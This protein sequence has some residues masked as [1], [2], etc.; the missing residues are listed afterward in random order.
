MSLPSSTGVAN[1]SAPPGSPHGAAI[2]I[3]GLYIAFGL[4]W[5][6]LSDWVILALGFTDDHAFLAAAI[7]G[8]A[9][10]GLTAMLLYTLVQRE[11]SRAWRS[12]NLLRAVVQETTD[13]VFVKDRKGRYLLANEAAARFIGRSVN[14]ILGRDDRELLDPAGAERIISNDQAIMAGGSVQT[15]EESITFTPSG[16]KHTFLATKAPYRDATG[17]VI[18]L[19]GISRDITARKTSEIA[20]QKMDA[21][22]REAQRITRMGSWSWEPATDQVWWSDAE[23][24]LLGAD[25]AKVKPGLEAFVSLLHPD[26]RAIAIARVDAIKAG[27]NE[28]ANDLRIIRPDG[29]MIWIHSR[30]RA[31]RDI[32]GALQL[33]EG[34]DQNI[35]EKVRIEAALR[36]ERDRIEKLMEAVPVAIASYQLAPDGSITMPYASPRIEAYYGI[37]PAALKQDASAIFSKVHPQDVERVRESVAE[38][39]KN[40][41]IWRDEY[42]VHSPV[43]GEIWIEGCSAPTRL[44]DGSVLW[45][46]YVNDVTTRKR[47]EAALVES[48][49]RFR[50]ALEAAGAFEFTIDI[51]TDAVTRHFS[52]E[53]ALP[54][55]GDQGGTLDD[56]RMRIHPDDLANFDLRLSACLASGTKYQNSCRVIRPDGT[57]AYIESHGYLDRAEDGS[58]LSLTGMGIDVTERVAATELLRVSEARYRQLVDLLPTALFVHANNMII[59]GNPAF[60]Q[61]MGAADLNELLGKS[62]F[63]ILHPSSHAAVRQRQERLRTTGLAVPGCEL[64]GLRLDGRTVPVYTVAAPIT[65]SGQQATL[66]ALSDLTE[67]ERATELLRSVMESVT[68]AIITIDEQA[69]IYSV[70][71]A[72]IKQFGYTQDELIT[73]HLGML[74]PEPC[75]QKDEGIFSCLLREG[76]TKSNGVGREVEC[77]RRDGVRFPAELTISEFAL[78]GKRRFTVVIRDLTERK[79]LQSRFIE[80]QKMEA[81]GRLAGGVAHDF[82]NLLTIINGYSELLLSSNAAVDDRSRESIATIR[83]AGTRAARLTQQLLAFSRKAVIEPKVIDLNFLVSESTQLLRRLIGEDIN[84][85][86]N[87]ARTPLRINADSSQIEQVI[88]NLVVNARDAMPTGGRLTIETSQMIHDTNAS[89]TFARLSVSDTGCG[90]TDEVKGKVFEPFFTTKGAGK[91]TGLGLAVV[92]GVVAQSGGQVHIESVVGAGTTFHLWFPLI[93]AEKSGATADAPELA[94]RGTG[95]ILVV[96]DEEAV[97]KIACISLRMQG[98]TVLDAVGGEEAIRLSESHAGEI[99]LLVSDVVMP[100][101]GGRQL[102]DALRERRPGLRA[103]FMSGYTDDAVLFHGVIEATDAF[104]QKPFTPQSLARKVRELIDVSVSAS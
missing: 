6:W 41:T 75:Q 62:P 31:T 14:E 56:V 59:Y 81:V 90:M 98:Y 72:A 91:G 78:D 89:T 26:D 9:F 46:G 57:I 29:T 69:F 38:S 44:S 10:I 2:R 12:E 67:R 43:L 32:S 36:A 83:D 19:V 74:L 25:P 35:T 1:H 65:I 8:S 18:G 100:E 33:V 54:I 23:F 76:A 102:L 28:F 80:A 17:S 34:T 86:V 95:T 49:R 47:A 50:L 77:C 104:L 73:R 58:P 15:F 68:D 4:L 70:N 85:V 64:L 94:G 39:A 45:H 61:L 97:R 37:S 40:M 79:R 20:L 60:S 42:R 92:D 103:L 22:L 21:R 7:K 71:Q 88:M 53:P 101:M 13:A 27:A 66:V 99:D 51:K 24:E 30:A 55:T 16:A 84:L 48:E 11:V 96:E 87:L 93:T 63:D 5:I 3:V 52:K 82:N